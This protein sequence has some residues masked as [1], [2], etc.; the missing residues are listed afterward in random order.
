M[1][2]GMGRLLGAIGVKA[3]DGPEMLTASGRHRWGEEPPAG[4]PEDAI[5]G[6]G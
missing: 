5:R 6:T 1:S 3:V 2:I 4:R